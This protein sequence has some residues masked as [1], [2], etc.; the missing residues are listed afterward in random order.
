MPDPLTLTVTEVTDG[1]TFVAAGAEGNTIT[2]RVWGIDA[3]ESGQPYGSAAT[4]VAREVIGGALV[5]VHVQDT[6][7]YG[8]HI[9]RVRTEYEGKDVDLGRSL[10][11]SG[12]A[13]HSRKYPTSDIL[14]QH[15]EEARRQEKGL[16][17]Q[18]APTPPWEHRDAAGDT[19]LLEAIHEGVDAAQDG[20]RWGRWLWRLLS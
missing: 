13:W 19:S 2:V 12:L 15:E 5:D 9:G 20:Y 6:G 17:E 3:P 16:W 18:P 7:P 11:L 8:R 4:Q 10:T 14:V 1:D